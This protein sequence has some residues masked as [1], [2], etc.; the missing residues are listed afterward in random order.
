ME[1]E[2]VIKE[3]QKWYDKAVEEMRKSYKNHKEEHT[4]LETLIE[5]I[6]KRIANLEGT[7]VDSKNPSRVSQIYSNEQIENIV[8]DEVKKLTVN[9]VSKESGI[10]KINEKEEISKGD[11][12]ASD[13][14]YGIVG[15]ATLCGI[16]YAVYQ[17][18]LYF[19]AN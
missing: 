19:V 9:V 8:K 6:S 7:Q 14:V 10:G 4:H 17:A 1:E 11:T 16:G 2:D 5:N 12:K 15:I 18:Y 13:I 3:M